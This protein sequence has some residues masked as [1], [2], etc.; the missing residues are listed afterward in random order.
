M[1]SAASAAGLEIVEVQRLDDLRALEREWAGLFAEARGVT[2]FLH[3]AWLL[4][5]CEAFGVERVCA[6]VV[7]HGS[8]GRLLA[9]LPS[10]ETGD[11]RATLALLGGDVSDHRGPVIRAGV[12]IE[13]GHALF[14]WAESRHSRAVFDDLPGSHPWASAAVPHGWRRAPACVCPTAP[15]PGSVE[16]WRAG[17]GHGLRRNLRRYT[18]RIEHL[19]RVDRLVADERN[20]SEIIEAFIRLHGARWL[21]RGQAGVLDAAA[22]Q[23]FHRTSAPRLQ[24]AGLL[25]LHA[26]KLDGQVVAVQHVLV[27]ERRAYGYLAGYDPALSSLSIGTVLVAAACEHAIAEGRREFD[28]LRGVE[29]YKYAWG[30]INQNTWRL[31][32]SRDDDAD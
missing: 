31:R 19:G 10:C 32:W 29:P 16:Q 5:W 22:A 20:V 7:R 21:A 25:R 13:A 11:A 12:E 4:A 6:A 1:A 24:R 28:F 15:L 2:P 23:R 27:H 8:T 14:T 9:V 26:W 30:A 3:P 17:L 18:A